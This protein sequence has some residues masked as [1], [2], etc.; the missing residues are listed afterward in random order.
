MGKTVVVKRGCGCGDVVIMLALIL[1]FMY[2]VSMKGCEAL[3][4]VVDALE[5]PAEEE[6]AMD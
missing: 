2:Y 4:D 3:V 5:E 1:G 6:S